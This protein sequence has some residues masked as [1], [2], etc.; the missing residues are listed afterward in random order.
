MTEKHRF[1]CEDS[2]DGIFTAVYDAWASRCGHEAVEISVREP[3]NLEFFCQYHQ[4]PSSSEKALKVA[5]TL[6][7]RLSVRE[8]ELICYAAVSYAEDKGTAVYQSLVRRLCFRERFTNQKNPFIRRINEL[9]KN[10][11]SE[12]HHLLGFTRFRELDSGILIAVIHPRNDLLLMLCEHFADRLPEENFVLWDRNR[13]R[14]CV[15]R[16][17][18]SCVLLSDISLSEKLQSEYAEAEGTWEALWREFCRSIAISGRK[19]RNLQRQLLPLRFRDTM[20][21]FL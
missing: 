5:R 9:Y 7:Q 14:A 10:T 18:S 8:Y 13:R 2:L 4:I 15:H 17:G 12:Y 3:E 21:E 6:R 1:I 19:N 11:W 16:A 20:T